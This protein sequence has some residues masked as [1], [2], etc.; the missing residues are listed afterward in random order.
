MEII[1]LHM[2]S[3]TYI[4][5]HR[6][7]G[8]WNKRILYTFHKIATL[9][10]KRKEKQTK[11]TCNSIRVSFFLLLVPLPLLLLFLQCG[12]ISFIFAIEYLLKFAHEKLSNVCLIC[13]CKGKISVVEWRCIFFP[14]FS[15]FEFWHTHKNLWSWFVCLFFS[16]WYIGSNE[17]L[18]IHIKSN[19]V[20]YPRG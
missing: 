2:L 19:F 13:H 11:E 9:P 18:N 1:E 15:L 3:T 17:L 5:T 20:I 6:N 8:H 12:I 10:K 14:T 7:M 16:Y 4:H